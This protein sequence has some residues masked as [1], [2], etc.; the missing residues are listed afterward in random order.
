MTANRLVAEGVSVSL[1]PLASIRIQISLQNRA[2]SSSCSIHFHCRPP[3]SMFGTWVQ[4][5]EAT[6]RDRLEG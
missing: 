3:I 4:A 1:F 2:S 5:W 6:W